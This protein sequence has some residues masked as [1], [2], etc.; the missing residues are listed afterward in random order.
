MYG[1]APGDLNAYTISV[2]SLHNTVLAQLS[3]RGKGSAASGI[4][5]FTQQS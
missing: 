2:I 1:K 3:S 4:E 5:Y